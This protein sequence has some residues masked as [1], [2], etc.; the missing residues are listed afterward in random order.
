MHQSTFQPPNFRMNSSQGK[1]ILSLI[2]SGDFA[3]A[4]EAEAVSMVLKGLPYST[5]NISIDVGCGLGGTCELIQQAVG[6]QVIGVDTDSET[7]TYA[8]SEYPKCEFI[9]GSAT[10]LSQYSI[11][12]VNIITMFNTFYTFSPQDKALREAYL[13]SQKGAQ[14]R[15]FDYS[16]LSTDA[17]MKEFASTYSRSSWYPIETDTVEQ[18][19]RATGWIMTNMTDVT[20]H[21]LR[22]YED[23]HQK[24]V[25]NQKSIS[26]TNSDDWYKYALSRYTILLDTL[27]AKI[28]GGVIVEAVRD[29][30]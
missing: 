23:L 17:R 18:R 8:H 9:L 28:I 27:K 3:H 26:A 21:Y 5:Q 6:G 29:S 14:L 16:G 15:I 13:V 10:E 2:R 1:Q 12:P 24:I 7:I 19:L 4:G 11:P 25:S 20:D 22:W 30:E